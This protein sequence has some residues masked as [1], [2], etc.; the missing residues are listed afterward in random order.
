MSK[1]ELINENIKIISMIDAICN[2]H[3]LSTVRQYRD[4]YLAVDAYT[5]QGIKKSEA[6]TWASDD[7]NISEQSVYRALGWFD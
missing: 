7:F 1:I 3:K 6:I 5:R 2:G 4:I